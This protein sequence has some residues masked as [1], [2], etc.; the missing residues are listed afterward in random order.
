[1]VRASAPRRA[2]DPGAE[3]GTLQVNRRK[4][5]EQKNRRNNVEFGKPRSSFRQADQADPEQGVQPM[6]W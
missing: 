5:T 2:P 1:M 6:R 3:V 4:S